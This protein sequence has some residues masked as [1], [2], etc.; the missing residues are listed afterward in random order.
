MGVTRFWA[1]SEPWSLAAQLL[2][3]VALCVALVVTGALRAVDDIAMG[4][5]LVAMGLAPLP[6]AVTTARRGRAAASSRVG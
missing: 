4:I 1:R 5:A 2:A 6:H 3:V